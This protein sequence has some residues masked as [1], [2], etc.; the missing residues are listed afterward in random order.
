MFSTTWW[1]SPP[2]TAVTTGRPMTPMGRRPVG[3]P[4]CASTP[5]TP[6]TESSRHEMTWIAVA[7]G[8]ALG[9]MAR[10]Y[11]NLEIAHRLERAVPWATF[12]V[13]VIGCLV[14]GLLAG[15]VASG[16]LHLSAPARTS[17]S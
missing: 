2:K 3:A 8:G 16:R 12:V 11:V 7:V 10:H 13:N 15:R 5:T 1:W 4:A 6:V 17:L 14:I 9:S